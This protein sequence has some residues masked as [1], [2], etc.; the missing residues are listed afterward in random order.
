MSLTVTSFLY[1]ERVDVFHVVY[2]SSAIDCD[3][4]T[5]KQWLPLYWLALFA[6]VIFCPILILV[7][8]YMK[9]SVIRQRNGFFVQRYGILF[10][11]YHDAAACFAVPL[12]LLRRVSF[13]GVNILLSL[14]ED[15][16]N[17]CFTM[18]SLVFLLVHLW[19]KPYKQAAI[20]QLESVLLSLLVFVGIVL[21]HPDSIKADKTSL[22]SVLLA[23]LVA[24]PVVVCVL[25]FSGISLMG[26][27]NK[28]KMQAQ[29]GHNDN[30]QMQS[31]SQKLEHSVSKKPRMSNNDHDSEDRGGVC[32]HVNCSSICDSTKATN[33]CEIE[34][35]EVSN[36]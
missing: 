13:I 22:T 34:L 32:H 19:L 1:C 2:F 18:L 15:Y 24:M 8:L 10:E 6:F 27:F 29:H 9:R 30:I 26:Y 33:S 25:Y 35:A 11:P 12:T 31:E 4:A 17:M 7:R 5:Y 16:R 14:N 3:S 28:R 21:S 23:L 36:E 20:N